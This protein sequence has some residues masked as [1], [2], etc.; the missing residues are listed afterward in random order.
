MK[1][2]IEY[3]IDFSLPIFII[4]FGAC[5]V[6]DLPYKKIT[7]FFILLTG[8]WTIIMTTLRLIKETK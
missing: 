5:G 2:I 6:F 4:S 1:S 3:L 8:I 7:F